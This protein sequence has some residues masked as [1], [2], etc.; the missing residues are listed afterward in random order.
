MSLP[1][2]ICSLEVPLH[3]YHDHNFAQVNGI[4][5]YGFVKEYKGQL[6]WLGELIDITAKRFNKDRTD[7]EQ[8]FWMEISMLSRLK[9]KN[10]VSLVGFCDENDEKIIIIRNE[11][12]RGML[13]KYLSDSMSL[14]WVRRLEI[15]VGLAHALSY[16]H[17]DEPRD[18]SVIHRAIECSRIL[19]NDKW[20]PKL[21]GFEY[22]MKIKA[23]QRHHS[24]HT[25]RVKGV[26]GYV[27]PTCL[28]TGTV[29][30]KSDMYSFGIVLFELLCGRKSISEHPDNKYLAPMAIFHYRDKTLDGIIDPDLWKQ[31]ETRSLNILTET[32]YDCLNKEQSQ[33]PNIDEIVTRLE[34]ALELQLERENV[35]HLV[36]AAEVEGIS[37]KN[38]KGSVT[39]ISIGNESHVSKKTKSILKDVSHLKLSYQELESATNNFDEENRV[40]KNG[41]NFSGRL[42]RSE[43]FIDIFV[44]SYKSDFPKDESKMFRVELSM[45]SSLKHKNLVSLIGFY[46]ETMAQSK[47]I[48]Y[49]REA[50]GSLQKYLSDQTLTWMQ[51]LKICVGVANALSY[52]HYDIGRDFSVIHCNIKS[53]I[54]LLDDKWEPKLSGFELSLKTTVARRHRLLLTRDIIENAYLDPKYKKTGGV[55]HKSDVYSFG[56]VLFEVLCGRSARRGVDEDKDSDDDECKDEDTDNGYDEDGD[57]GDDDE[58]G[59]GLLSQLAK[60][61]LDEM[62]DPHLRKQMDPKSFKIFSETAYWCIKEDRAD[63]PYIDQV[64]KR[65]EKALELQWK[66]EN[67]VK[68]TSSIQFEGK[69]LEHLKIGLNDI[70]EATNNFDDA[71]CIGTGGFGKVYK[72]VLEHLYSS[73]SLSIEGV[74]ECNLSRKRSTVAIKRINNKKGEQGFIAEIETLTS[75]KHENIIS[76][77]GF[78]YEGTG[79]M[80]LV[81]EHAS[82][83]SLENYLGSSDKMN[84]TW[85]QRLNICLDIAQGLNYIHNNTDHGKQKMLHRD[86]KSDNILLGDNWNAKIADFGL[87][88]FHPADQAASTIYTNMIAGTYVYLDPEYQEDGKLNKKSDI[89]SFGVVLLEILSGRLAYDSVYTKV[90]DK[91]IA[92]IARDHF[93]KRTIMEI[94]DHKIKEE[95]DEHVFSLSKG[96][97]KESLDTFLEIA[98]RC[99]AETQAQ[100]PTIEVVINELKKAIDSQFLRNLQICS[101]WFPK[102]ADLLPN[103]TKVKRLDKENEK[104]EA[105]FATELEILT[106]YKHENVIGLVG[107]CNEE[108]EKII[109]YPNHQR[110]VGVPHGTYFKSRNGTIGY[111]DPLHS[112]T[113]FLTKESDIFSLG[114]VLFDI[115]CGKISPFVIFQGLRINANHRRERSGQWQEDYEIWEP[116]LPKDYKE[117]IQM[118]KCPEI[119]S[120]IKKEELYNTFSKGILLQQD[121]V[122]LSFNGFGERN[123]MVSAAMFSYLNSC[124]HE[125]KSLQESRFET[126]VEMFDLSKLN[127]EIK[128]NTQ[129]LTPNVV[130][131][132]YLVFKL[133]DSRQFSSNPMYVNLKYRKGL[134]SLHAYFAT[135]RHKDWMMI[136][137]YQFLN[138]DEDTVFDFLLESFSSYHCGDGAVYVEGI[139]FRAIDEVKH[140]EIGKLKEVQQVLKSNFN[141]DQLQQLPTNFEE[142]FKICRNYDELFWLGEVNEKKL[143][144]VSAKAVLYKFSNVDLFTSKPLAESRFQEVIELLPQQ[145]F[146]LNCTIKSQMLS[147]DTEYVCYLVFK[148][149][150]KCQGLHCPVKVRDILHKVNNEAEFVYFIIPSTLN[151]N[152]NTRVPKQREDEWMEIQVWKFNSAQEFKDN[153]LSIDMKFTSHE[154]PMSGLIVCGLEFRPTFIG[155][156]DDIQRKRQKKRMLQ[157]EAQNTHIQPKKD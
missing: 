53:S 91:G 86:I 121:K 19:L 58:L 103:F 145:V 22:S 131:G 4:R 90:N 80:I 95:T 57:N 69:N 85:V 3:I 136:E 130:Y 13:S 2:C 124:P 129:L 114:A 45:L 31:M 113:G 54:I 32:A 88:K 112:K 149:S 93:E 21:S 72:A 128:T 123:K 12:A 117:I 140:E 148:L 96:P 9:H 10:V 70:N 17:Y 29:N 20:E 41:W 153:S 81:Y 141:V 133:S 108:D 49:K 59:E 62:I 105:E 56:V 152:G 14:T 67:P 43:Q 34:K 84:L 156:S 111:H 39:S 63:R 73:N 142:I 139:E 33:R 119:Y 61:H 144:V 28:E 5:E 106:E 44:K 52:I 115:M 38:E 65:L 27:D 74:D 6:L 107:Y 64:V 101:L 146:H 82:K 36:A 127:I 122:V 126:V 100:R 98:F 42:L 25:N 137:L 151:I 99:V 150:E 55:T 11:T 79:A 147:Q 48:I 16:I 8:V 92:P 154:G 1:A 50:N 116:K 155:N 94:V 35:V 24:F 104:G 37:S 125:W 75:C 30:H 110:K 71:Y 97:N 23:S 138:Q 47:A 60:S 132:V 7:R 157:D 102:F 78:C 68:R 46:D 143:L 135:W 66:H 40:N 118:S 26:K 120:T 87:S 134:E 18:F 76:L 109:V 89:Y 83:G 15:C 77:L 51:R